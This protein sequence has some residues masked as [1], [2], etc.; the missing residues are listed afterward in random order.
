MQSQ[1]GLIDGTTINTGSQ[2]M[3]I[4][5]DTYIGQCFARIKKHDIAL[6]ERRGQFFVLRCYLFP[7]V[8]IN[9]CSK[10][11]RYVYELLG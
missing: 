10:F 3:Q 1:F 9:R 11:I 2:C 5:Q 4:P 8:H 6:T 7:M